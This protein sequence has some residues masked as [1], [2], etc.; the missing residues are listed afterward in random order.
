MSE[1]NDLL[2][3][4]EKN[5]IFANN[6]FNMKKI[7]VS[8]LTISISACCYSQFAFGL[9]ANYNNSL[10]FDENWNFDAEN[11]KMS[12]GNS[13]GVGLGVFIRGGSKFFVQPELT[14]N[15]MLTRMKLQVDNNQQ[16]TNNLRLSTINLPV[17]FGFKVLNMRFFNIR[18][19]A[20]PRFRFNLGSK[21]DF[22]HSAID[23]NALPRKWQLGLDTGV[24]FDLGKITVD[25]RYNL[26]QDIFN[27]TYG[28]QKARINKN[29]INSFSVGLGIKFIDIKL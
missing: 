14:Y 24:G 5:V 13:H 1:K 29:P 28:L 23:V 8:I 9:L 2:V 15:F 22:S 4:S 16:I 21:G 12:N 19:M 6:D 20:G 7:L 3:L 18:L 26:M 10:S 27:Y 25:V 11:L 17:L